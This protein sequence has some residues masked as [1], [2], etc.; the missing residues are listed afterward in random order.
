MER[1]SKRKSYKEERV[2]LSGMLAEFRDALEE[3]I[4]KIEKSGQSSTLLFSGRQIESHSGDFWYQF[5]VEYAPSLPADTPCKLTIGKEQFDVTVISFA[6]TSIII[7]SKKQL[8]ATIGQAQLENGATVLME[9]LIKCIE[10]NA[11]V[12]NSSGNKMFLQN[13]EVYQAQSIF[14]YN[15][16]ELNDNNTP[17]QSKAIVSAISN[18]ITYI[19]GPPGTGKTTVIGQIIDELYKHDRS[20]LVVS[21]TNTAVD[22]AIEKADRTYSKKHQDEDTVYPILRLGTPAKLLPERVLLAKHIEILGKELYEQK[23]QLENQ[24]IEAQRRINEIIPLL[25]KDAWIRESCLETIGKTLTELFE[26]ESKIKSLTFEIETTTIELQK[27]KEAHPEYARYLVL[28]RDIKSKKD[29]LEGLSKQIQK[30][31]EATLELPKRIQFIRDEIR[32]HDVYAKLRAEEAKF[33]SETFLKQEISRINSQIVSLNAESNVLTARQSSAQRIIFDYE[34]K[35]SVAKLFAGKSAVSQAKSDIS[36]ISLQLSQVKENL[37]RSNKLLDEYKQQFDA[38]LVIQEQIKAVTPSKTQEYWGGELERIQTQLDDAQSILPGLSSKKLMLVEELASLEEHQKQAKQYNDIVIELTG[39]LR[40]KQDE[41]NKL[42]SSTTQSKTLCSEML[43]KE[44]TLCAA[45]YYA[46][47]ATNEETLYQELI[48]LF[49]NINK[50]V[51]TLDFEAIRQEKETIDK[52]ISDIFRQLNELKE[53]MQELEKQAIAN[54]KIV[55]ATLAKTYLSDALRERKFDTVILDE[56]SMASIPAL[57]CASY[58]A[59]SSIVIVGD[60]LQLP[61][62]VMAET[63]M[64]QEWLGKDIFYHSG[65]QDRAKKPKT[66]PSNFVMLNDQFRMESDIADIAN[67][68]Y[69]EY[70]GL[71]SNDEK[72]TSVRDAFYKW[73]SGN[74][75]KQH[76]H[77]VDTENLHAWVTGVPQGKSHSRLN[78]FSAAVDVDLAFKFLENKLKDLDPD[79]AVPEKEPSVLIVAPY[80]PHIARINQLI[81]LEYRNR[82]FKENLNFIRAG[83]IHS[84]QGSEA[85]IVI[86][87]LVI[88]EPHWKANLFMTEKA[89]NDDLRKMFNVAVTRAKFKLFVVGNFTYCQKRAKNNALSELLDKLINKD[90][91]KKIDAKDILP[92]I[93]FTRKSDFAISGSLKGKH[94]VCRE[95]SFN[96]YFMADIRSFKQRLIVYSPFMTEARLSL[97]LPAFVDAINEG[98]QIIVVTK[99]LSD[100]GRTELAQYQKCEQELRDIGVNVLHKKGMH[101]KLIFVDSEAVWIGSLNALSFTGLTG[102]IMQRHADKKLTAEYEKLFDIPHICGVVENADEQKCPICQGEMLLKESDEGGIYWQCTNGDYS[103][104]AIQQY[105]HD[106]VLRCKCGAPNV[107]VMKN[108]PRWVCSQDTRHFQKMRESD[109]KLEKMAALIPTKAERK[110]VDNFFADKKKE[111]ALDKK[112]SSADNEQLS[113]F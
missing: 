103:R 53:K 11:E 68:Y 59:E 4:E 56:A 38:L 101:E 98:K 104:N 93:T 82:G 21:H 52:H 73:Y 15:D 19:W 7:S 63:P 102:E 65:M 46:P 16:I 87:D 88:D 43:D 67:M 41:L 100:R 72:R 32:K 81:E 54:A 30:Y 90:K 108:E 69:G 74:R 78:C 80:K 26:I 49:S 12:E 99:A 6:E 37:Q 13:G 2:V 27:Q 35:S 3:E 60:F 64:A 17:N 50:E 31:S 40:Q 111:K 105:P 71:I 109:L 20:V 42:Q 92:K 61:P 29:E 47:T 10:A 86:F 45:F 97:L 51:T 34:R 1:R 33:M 106:G 112:V 70:G 55:G 113:L 36:A 9:R 96:E 83:T 24:Q 77:L 62:I 14:F 94:I 39:K 28:S 107:Y 85:D 58:L 22:G 89:V 76:V 18:D 5:N 75:T 91:L 66:C 84:F 23:A 110:K 48:D 25:A 57:W 44:K 95:E 79:N 8:P